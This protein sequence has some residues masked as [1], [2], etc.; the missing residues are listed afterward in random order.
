DYLGFM[1]AP[2]RAARTALHHPD[3]RGR[4]EEV[5][6]IGT[7]SSREYIVEARIRRHDGAYRWHR[8]HNKPLLRDQVPIGWIGPAVDIH[9]I[10]EANAALEH[11]VRLRT[12][13]LEEA[14]QRLRQEVEQRRLG[15]VFSK[16]DEGRYGLGASASKVYDVE[17]GVSIG[18]DGGRLYPS[19]DAARGDVRG[20]QDI[21]RPGLEPV[22][23]GDA[24]GLVHVAV[25]LAGRE[26]VLLQALGQFADRGLAIAEHDRRADVVGPQ[27]GA[28]GSPPAA[29]RL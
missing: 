20:D 27:E 13:E 14:N 12:A 8:I 5:R 19:F 28:R 23:F 17:R 26:T 21:D 22:Q 10:R 4:L 3:D 1:P 18:G 15:A 2:D 16:P 7:A 11:R 25:D 9:D 29:A 6:A 24:R